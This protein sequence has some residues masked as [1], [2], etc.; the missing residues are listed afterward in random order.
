MNYKPLLF[1]KAKSES[2]MKMVDVM[3]NRGRSAALREETALKAVKESQVQN[4]GAPN[5]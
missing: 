3:D 5:I 2:L 4:Q 1:L